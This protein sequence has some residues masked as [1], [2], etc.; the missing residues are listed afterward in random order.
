[1]R[2]QSHTYLDAT[3]NLDM[4]NLNTRSID[5]TEK[6]MLVTRMDCGDEYTTVSTLNEFLD[7]MSKLDYSITLSKIYN[8]VYLY[9]EQNGKNYSKVIEYYSIN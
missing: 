4:Y 7:N 8:R 2:N 1:M 3:T 6:V 5:G 9:T